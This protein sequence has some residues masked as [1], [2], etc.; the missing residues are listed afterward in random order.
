MIVFQL[1]CLLFHLGVIQSA[2]IIGNNLDDNDEGGGGE[3]S[4][5]Q[6]TQSIT[7]YIIIIP[8]RVHVAVDAVRY[9]TID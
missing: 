3:G 9:Y 7:F 5:V 8:W 2:V 1:L 6:T 4:V